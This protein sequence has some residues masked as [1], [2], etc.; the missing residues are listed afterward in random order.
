[1]PFLLGAINLAI[2]IASLIDIIRIPDDRVRYL[3]KMGWIIVVILLPF[4]G[5]LLWWVIGREY[6]QRSFPSPRFPQQ[7]QQTAP[8]PQRPQPAPYRTT[9]QQLADLEREEYEAKLREELARRR[10]EREGE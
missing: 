2:F 10:K 8:Q 3:P 4:I 1:M 5:S 7:M 9:E 6:E